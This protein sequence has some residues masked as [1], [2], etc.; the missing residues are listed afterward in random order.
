[1]LAEGYYK[2]TFGDKTLY[3]IDQTVDT[4]TRFSLGEE[5]Q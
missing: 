4:E 5:L 3:I 1:V 2:C